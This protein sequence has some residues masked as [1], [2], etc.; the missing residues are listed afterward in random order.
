MSALG[1]D[2]IERRERKV[3]PRVSTPQAVPV[4]TVTEGDFGL[5]TQVIVPDRGVLV[6]LPAPQIDGEPVTQE[7]YLGLWRDADGAEIY[8]FSRP[9][10]DEAD[11]S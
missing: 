7:R 6:M 9:V 10:L 2:R 5:C 4:E 1:D 11:H 8:L 3:P